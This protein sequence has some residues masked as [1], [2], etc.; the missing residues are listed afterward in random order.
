MTTRAQSVAPFVGMLAFVPIMIC[1]S[2]APNA[3]LDL[4][5][6]R[7]SMESWRNCADPHADPCAPDEETR[8]Q[9]VARF[10]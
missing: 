6:S 4:E 10:A 9:A 7:T 8:H 5:P 2:C 1:A 3:K